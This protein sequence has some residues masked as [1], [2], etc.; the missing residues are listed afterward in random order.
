MDWLDYR[1][2][3]GIGFNDTQKYTFFLNNVFSTLN[4]FTNVSNLGALSLSEYQKFCNMTGTLIDTK[5]FS[6]GHHYERYSFCVNV[7]DRHTSYLEEFLAYYVAFINS[8]E[9]N[10]QSGL[11]RTVLKNILTNSLSEAHIPYEL[12]TDNDDYFVFPKGVEEFDDALVSQPLSWLKDYPNAEKAWIKALREY[13]EEKAE[14]ASDVAD[15]FRKALEAFF[16]EFFGGGKT[17]ENYKSDYGAYLKAQGVPSTIANNF[18]TLLQAYT[19]FMNDCAKHHDATSD[20]V[21]EYLM[22]QTGNI[23]RLLIT[24]KQGEQQ[25]AD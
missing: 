20:N 3:L 12:L 15:M 23:M 13:S 21:L 19:N 11:T 18:E 9:I 2:K 4:I 7:L 1:E 10:R 14:K 22:Y 25:N 8:A 24:L 6:D 16:Q 5:I 17:L